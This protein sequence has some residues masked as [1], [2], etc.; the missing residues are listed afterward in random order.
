MSLNARN[1]VPEDVKIRA[2]EAYVANGSFRKTAIA[3]GLA[4]NTLRTATKNFTGHGTVLSGVS[5]AKAGRKDSIHPGL[6]EVSKKNASAW[7]YLTT[8]DTF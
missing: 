7:Q 3:F 4:T 1:I 2:V 8:L 6:A 5:K